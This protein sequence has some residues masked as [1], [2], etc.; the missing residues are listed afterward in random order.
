MP[1][2]DE[3]RQK[4]ME[5]LTQDDLVVAARVEASLKKI[6]HDLA[7][8]E[9]CHCLTCT[10]YKMIRDQEIRKQARE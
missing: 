7:D 1:L 3:D 8:E 6:L 9:D 10:V 5:M 2:S 4:I